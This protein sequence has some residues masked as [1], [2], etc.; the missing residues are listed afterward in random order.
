MK[1][2]NCN[3]QIVDNKMFCTNCG[4]KLKEENISKMDPKKSFMILVV[5]MLLLGAGT[6]YMIANFGT[7]QEL[8]KILQTKNNI[9]DYYDSYLI[10]DVVF[11]DNSSNDLLPLKDDLIGFEM[12]LSKDKFK[13]GLFQVLW[14]TID[15]PKITTMNKVDTYKEQLNVT[16]EEVNA[17]R[18]EGTNIEK[19]G[20]EPLNFDMISVGNKLFILYADIYFELET[21]NLD[22]KSTKTYYKVDLLKETYPSN[23]NVETTKINEQTKSDVESGSNEIYISY[24][25]EY[26]DNDVIHLVIRTAGGYINSEMMSGVRTISFNKNTGDKYNLKTYLE[27]I[28]KNYDEVILK[29]EENREIVFE[30]SVDGVQTK[31][32]TNPDLLYYVK[33]NKIYIACGQDQWGMLFAEVNLKGE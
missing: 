21:S 4:K 32:E 23:I 17:I 31:F 33:E 6:L 8:D 11:T 29:Y 30:S 9:E 3:Q 10:K 25:E 18:I 22:F 19:E 12:E 26:T 5:V 27:H 14:A 20:G 28:G 2:P 16:T 15:K 24:Y 13:I 7:Q 1:C